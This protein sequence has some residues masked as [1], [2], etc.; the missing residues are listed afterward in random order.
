MLCSTSGEISWLN[1]AAELC[2]SQDKPKQQHTGKK[3]DRFY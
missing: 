2:C 1:K 3:K